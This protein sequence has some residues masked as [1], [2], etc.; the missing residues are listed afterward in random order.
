MI[1]P[2]ILTNKPQKFQKMLDIC[3]GFTDYVQI[4]IMDAKFVPSKSITAQQLKSCRSP[5]LLEAHL[6]VNKPLEW[7]EAFK[8]F[9]TKRISQ[10][11]DGEFFKHCQ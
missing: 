11:Y 8:K 4:D 5:L 6:M 9:K 7:L 10:R 3:A 2:A 1:L